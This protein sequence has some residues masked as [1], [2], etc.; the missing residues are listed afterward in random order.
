M[1]GCPEATLLVSEEVSL[2]Q[3]GMVNAASSV[4]GSVF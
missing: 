4:C 3:E 1:L 2:L